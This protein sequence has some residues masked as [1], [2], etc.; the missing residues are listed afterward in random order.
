MKHAAKKLLT[1]FLTAGLVFSLS[2]MTA[3]ATEP[4]SEASDEM[5][6][7]EMTDEIVYEGDEG[8]MAEA[9]A[10]AEVPESDEEAIAEEDVAEKDGEADGEDAEADGEE[11]EADGEDEEDAGIALLSVE[12][13]DE[14]DEDDILTLGVLPDAVEGTI[15]LEDD[16][17]LDGIWTVEGS[18]TLDL[19]GK[20]LTNAEDPSGSFTF[21]E[22]TSI[23]TA[24]IYVPSGSSLTITDSVGS[25]EVTTS[26]ETYCIAA[27]GGTVTIEGGTFT[28]SA[29]SDRTI[30]V[31]EGSM[32]VVDGGTIEATGSSGRGIHA[33]DS[34]V[35]INAGT[36]DCKGESGYAV[37]VSGCELTVN[38]GNF[39]SVGGGIYISYLEDDTG[40]IAY[41]NATING[42]SITVTGESGTALGVSNGSNVK[43][44]DVTL[45][46]SGFGIAYYGSTDYEETVLT[47]NGG[48]YT[49]AQIGTS[50]YHYTNVHLIVNGGTFYATGTASEEDPAGG[51]YFPCTGTLD[52]NGG[53]LISASDGIIIR[54]GTLNMTGG[55]IEANGVPDEW[56]DPDE[57]VSANSGGYDGVGILIGQHTVDSYSDRNLKVNISGGEIYG[58]AYA[59]LENDYSSANKH[60]YEDRIHVNI[61]GG[62]FTSSGALDEHPMDII[63]EDEERSEGALDEAHITG[64]FYSNHVEESDYIDDGYMCVEGVSTT[65]ASGKEYS[66][67]HAVIPD[68]ITEDNTTFDID[69]DTFTYNGSSQVPTVSN[70]V[71]QGAVD[72]VTLVEDKH[73]TVSYALN[74]EEKEE[75][76]VVNVNDYEVLVTGTGSDAECSFDKGGGD[77]TYQDSL[78]GSVTKSFSIVKASQDISY[79]TDSVTK[80]ESDASF[81][82][83]LT[84]T[85]VYGQITYSSSDEAVAMVDENGLVTIIG[86]GTATI[87]AT[88]EGSENY[89]E[90]TAFYT[91]IVT[92]EVGAT[93]GTGPGPVI[94]SPDDDNPDTQTGPRPVIGNPDGSNPESTGGTQTG[95]VSMTYL[96]ILLIIAAAAFVVAGVIFR[97]RPRVHK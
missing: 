80:S 14:D 71:I 56:P 70:V 37:R 79:A 52:F 29:E 78:D 41:S 90:A 42:G 45:E 28:D 57:Q 82:N 23:G 20:T 10:E 48:T 30:W 24:L 84:E 44:E 96:W 3:L 92:E 93:T 16:V 69:Q 11:A 32:L 75:A 17:E 61:S 68:Q 87:T 18:I 31:S 39:T 8:D 1:F 36:I 83:E 62:I 67:Y 55:V 50:G 2:G 97:T 38:G 19:N 33:Q 13:E 35:T 15:T 88:A 21:S 94:G 25:G 76:G 72:Q 63:D 64:G 53:T 59:L 9:E 60:G 26:A 73:Y 54:D 5:N 22:D 6:P 81:T 12:G 85:T 7:P 74:G 86:P 51:F 65:G 95:D 47:I 91:L 46:S 4:D 66:D 77:H 27:E 43:V 89:D 49:A 40:E 34:T 58:Y